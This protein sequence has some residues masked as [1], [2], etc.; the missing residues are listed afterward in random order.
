MVDFKK[1][2]ASKKSKSE[3]RRNQEAEVPPAESPFPDNEAFTDMAI[4]DLPEAKPEAAPEA[5]PEAALPE[6]VEM[7]TVTGKEVVTHSAGTKQEGDANVQGSSSDPEVKTYMREP[8]EFLPKSYSKVTISLGMT[9][10]LGDFEFARVDVEIE[11]YCDATPEA[12]K[13]CFTKIDGEARSMM[14]TVAN[15]IRQVRGAR[16]G[17]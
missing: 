4:G 5:L 3:G 7:E 6:A 15:R 12:R 14:M 10:S 1:A 11:E 9:K 2:A 16:N 17:L 13:E 8:Q